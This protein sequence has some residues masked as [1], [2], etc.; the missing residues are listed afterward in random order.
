MSEAVSRSGFKK[1]DIDEVV[2]LGGSSKLVM[3]H[4]KLGE[5]FPVEKIR[6]GHSP[7]QTVAIS[8][9]AIAYAASKNK[10]K[11]ELMEYKILDI[12][13]R[14]QGIVVVGNKP[15]PFISK[16]HERAAY[17]VREGGSFENGLA[18]QVIGNLTLEGDTYIAGSRMTCT[19]NLDV[20]YVLTVSAASKEED[21][22]RDE[23]EGKRIEVP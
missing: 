16:D 1:H 20:D 12:T 8:A 4:T 3:V 21:E 14:S 18:N 6:S 9:A 13:T 22:N 15:H 2:L 5:Y 11:V 23:I 17:D 10:E 19:F 7:D